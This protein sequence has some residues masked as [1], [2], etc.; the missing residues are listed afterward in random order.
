MSRIISLAVLLT[1]IVLLG[2]TLYQVV[3]PFLLPLFLAAVLAVICQPLHRY[4][5]RRTGGHPAWAAAYSTVTLVAILVVPLVVATFICALQLYSMA[6]QHLDGDW[7]QAVD[8]FWSRVASPLVERIKPVVPGGLTDERI[9]ELKSQFALNLQS[10]AGEIAG[11]TFQIAS[12]T[13][14]M[15]ISLTVAAGMFVTALYYFLADG[16]AF[17]AAAE[18]LIPLPIDHQRRL[19]ERFATVV[20]AVVTATFLSAFAQG[21]ATAVAIQF[22]GIGHFWIFLMI[23]SVASI[24]PLAGAWMVWVPCVAWL[25]LHGQIMAPILLT[26]WGVAVSSMLD[27][28][29]KMYVLQNDADLHPL[30]AFISVVGALQVLGLWG[31][32]IGPIVAA[33]LFALIQIFN[34][35][36][37]ELASERKAESPAAK[38]PD[39][40]ATDLPLP[41]TESPAIC[42]APPLSSQKISPKPWK[43]KQKR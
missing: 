13:V 35:E 7:H 8:M 37:K 19:C 36:L 17:V 2:S 28:G 32:F 40:A 11:R 5:R 18:E 25:A 4:F 20:R 14:G 12:S 3:A 23:A 26:V 10:L 21:F 34:T 29:V 30:L 39:L 24:I 42:D 9:D 31:I 38:P 15:F 41:T 27:S 33:C 16:P 1:L 6:H 43:Q 22:C